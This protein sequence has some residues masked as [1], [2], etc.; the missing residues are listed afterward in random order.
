MNCPNCEQ[1]FNNTSL[2]KLALFFR[3]GCA[4]CKTEA[5]VTKKVDRFIVIGLL[6]GIGILVA[7]MAKSD[8][9]DFH[10]G[11]LLG[12]SLGFVLATQYLHWLGSVER[13][14]DFD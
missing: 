1:E 6:F 3:A 8:G 12:F 13:V 7:I 11:Q 10:A 9:A 2:A 14:E 4:R 5:T